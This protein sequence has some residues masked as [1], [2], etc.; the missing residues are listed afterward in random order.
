[1][2]FAKKQSAHLNMLPVTQTIMDK[3]IWELYKTG[4]AH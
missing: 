3:A 2:I 1:M 4:E